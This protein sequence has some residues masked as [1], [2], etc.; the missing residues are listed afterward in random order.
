MDQGLA[1]FSIKGQIV[2]VLSFVGHLISVVTAQCCHCSEKA[3][4]DDMHTK[5][6]GYVPIKLYS[7][8]QMVG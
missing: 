7:H 1:T 6:Y 4:I 2:N 8:I 3:A 5:G